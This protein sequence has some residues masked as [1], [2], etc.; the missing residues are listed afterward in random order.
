MKTTANKVTEKIVTVKS[1]NSEILKSNSIIKKETEKIELNLKEI[2]NIVL[3]DIKKLD[4]NL[5]KSQKIE[6]LKVHYNIRDY[7]K[8]TSKAISSILDYMQLK[9]NVT[10]DFLSVTEFYSIISLFKKLKALPTLKN[11]KKNIN[12][13]PNLDT[14]VNKKMLENCKAVQS[15]TAFIKESR[16]FIKKYKK[17]NY[18]NQILATKGV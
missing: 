3:T 12:Y 13:I 11:G 7:D 8:K 16:D 4:T 17:E 1:L 15:Y 5:S 2:F 10:F 14:V 9:I 6:V 18:I